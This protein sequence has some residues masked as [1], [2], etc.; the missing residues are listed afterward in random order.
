MIYFD[1]NLCVFKV[2]LARKRGYLYSKKP[3]VNHDWMWF[4]RFSNHGKAVYVPRMALGS[5]GVSRRSGMH[6]LEKSMADM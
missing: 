6:G 5:R 1:T 2:I 3:R 4:G